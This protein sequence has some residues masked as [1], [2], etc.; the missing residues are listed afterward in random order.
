MLEID[1]PSYSVSTPHL[2]TLSVHDV[3]Q[4]HAALVEMFQKSM[5]P[6][7][8]PGE[9]AGGMLESA[10]ARQWAGSDGKLLYATPA[11]NAAALAYG[12]C[13]NHPFANGNKRTAIVAM[14]V[15]L[16][17][18]GL[19]VRETIDHR[20]VY[21]FILALAESE[22]H[23]FTSPPINADLRKCAANS[24]E[25]QF[26]C[27]RHWIAIAT[28]DVRLGDRTIRMRD[29]RRILQNFG[30]ELRDPYKNFADIVRFSK[31]TKRSWL[32][33]S[34]TQSVEEKVTQISC[35]GMNSIVQV[36]TV[37][38]VRKRCALR[39]E[40]GVDSE[41]FYGGLDRLDFF[42]NHYRKILHRLANQ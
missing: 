1:S 28:R 26:A 20:D 34:S 27:C 4:I 14:L 10:V 2:R 40:D 17:K 12:L 41:I 6:I 24:Y 42:L 3:R 15:H 30:Y 16:D 36:N 39:N 32:G 22:L 23:R 25:Y 8:P 35:S 11:A 37:K 5:D 31:V 21:E 18:N 29:L 33:F 19:M 7:A 9:R 38:E 13:K